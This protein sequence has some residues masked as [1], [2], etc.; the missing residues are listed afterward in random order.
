MHK[1]WAMLWKEEGDEARVHANMVAD[2]RLT[3]M[4]APA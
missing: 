4:H 1:L 2:Q 3:R